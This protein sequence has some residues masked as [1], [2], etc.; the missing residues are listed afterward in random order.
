V[1]SDNPVGFTAL[2]IGL[3]VVF[4]ALRIWGRNWTS[5]EERERGRRED[6][7]LPWR[8]RILNFAPG[9][10]KWVNVLLLVVTVVAGLGMVAFPLYSL[11]SSAH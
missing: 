6:A 9:E 2:I 3:F 11:F 5:A 4:G 8:Q 1:A 10:P 7:A